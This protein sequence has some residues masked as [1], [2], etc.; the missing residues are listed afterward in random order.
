MTTQ[1]QILALA[2]CLV[3]P[4]L[5]AQGTHPITG[6]RIAPVMSADGADW[7]ERS[8]RESEERP[9]LALQLLGIQ[10][11][12][13]VADVGAGSGYYTAMLARQVGPSGK[14][15][16]SDIQPGMIER[17]NARL[18]REKIRNVETFLATET[19][20]RLPPSSCDLI[21][22]VDVYHEFSQPQAMLRN[23]RAALKPGGR[24][25]L[26]EFREED[27]KV[28]IR[29][30]HKMSVDEV[31]AELEPEGFRLERVLPDL[32]WQ[33]ILIFRK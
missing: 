13:L 4:A 12:M 33:H 16:A 29:P 8:E 22:L 14:V 32:P 30:E 28:P 17:L 19:D 27:P 2:L 20:A 21:L 5:R 3:S 24:L 9:K 11:G 10:P 15:F 31:R 6:R 18:R 7:L 1:A 25:V 26:L 23:L